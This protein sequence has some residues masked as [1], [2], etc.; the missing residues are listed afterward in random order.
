MSQV[1]PLGINGD[2]LWLMVHGNAAFDWEIVKNPDV[3]VPCE[4]MNR[5]AA[6][7]DLGK[8]TQET[9]ESAWNHRFVFEPEVEDVT[10]QVNCMGIAFDLI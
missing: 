1:K 4:K 8:F 9:G 10:H 5:Y 7:G 2:D 3:V 6:V